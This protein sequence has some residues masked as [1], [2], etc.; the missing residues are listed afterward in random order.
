M[1]NLDDLDYT[2]ISNMESDETI[3]LL[4]QIRLSRRMPAK[5]VSKTTAKRIQKAE[6]VSSINADTAAEILKLLGG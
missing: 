3:E 6:V 2:S 4:R 5:K 1:A